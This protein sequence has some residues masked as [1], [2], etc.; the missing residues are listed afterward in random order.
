MFPRNGVQIMYSVE[1]ICRLYV[2]RTRVRPFGFGLRYPFPLVQTRRVFIARG[3]NEEFEVFVNGSLTSFGEVPVSAGIDW[4]KYHEPDGGEIDALRFSLPE[5]APNRRLVSHFAYELSRLVTEQPSLTN[6]E[7]L[8]TVSPFIRLIQ[9]Q[10]MLG[11]QEQKGLFG[12]L[13]FLDRLLDSCEKHSLAPE[14][15]L[16]AWKAARRNAS[17]DFAGNGIVVEVKST[18]RS[19][20][21][22]RITSLQQLELDAGEVSLF[23]YSVSVA[24]DFSSETRLCDLVERQLNRLGQY[25]A[26]FEV[27]LLGRGYDLRLAN[28]YRLATP[29]ATTRFPVAMFEVNEELPRLRPSDFTTG[30]LPSNVSDLSYTLNLQSF[31]SANN[32]LLPDQIDACLLGMLQ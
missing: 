5:D 30:A 20:R 4:G 3:P 13:L 29:F 15:A 8:L 26:D 14:R 11:V 17:R 28:S 10:E 23:L 24:P 31:R 22:H 27:C 21:E 19:V 18:A 12:E 6:R 2:D 25:A 7:L 16:R 32:P 1:D 9:D